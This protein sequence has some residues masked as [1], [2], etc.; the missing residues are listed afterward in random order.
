MTATITLSLPNLYAGTTTV[1][2]ER[3]QVPE[4]FV[5]SSVTDEL[6]TRIQMIQQQVMSRARLSELIDRLGLYRGTRRDAPL[7]KLADQIGL[8]TLFS[9]FRKEPTSSS[10]PTS[11]SRP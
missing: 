10:T 5:K 7:D 2:V 8:N 11:A 3:R 4:E 6:E 1:L 9:R